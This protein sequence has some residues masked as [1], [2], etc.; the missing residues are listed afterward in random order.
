MQLSIQKTILPKEEWVKF[1][2]VS[3][4]SFSKHFIVQVKLGEYSSNKMQLV[5]LRMSTGD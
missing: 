5:F 2:E 3:M 1:E 4:I